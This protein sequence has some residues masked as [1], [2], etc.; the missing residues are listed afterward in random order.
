MTLATTENAAQPVTLPQLS[1][2]YGEPT[3]TA[4]LRVQPE[5]FMVH[6][7]LSFTPTGAGEHMLL[8]VE[9][10]GQNTQY[11]AKLLAEL[12]GCKAR[13]VSYAG[14]K[15]RHAITR[16]WFCVPVPIKQQL[17]WQQWQ[18]EGVKIL[19]SIRH[20]RRLKL[21]AI[22]YNQFSLML[23]EV[24]DIPALLARLELVKQGVPNYYGEQRFGIQG[25]NLALAEQLFSGAGIADR[26]IR[27]LALSASRSFLF[28][29]QL[30]ERIKAGFFNQILSGEVVQLDGS[31]SIF[32]VPEVDDSLKQRLQQADIHPTAGLPGSGEPLLSAEALHFE[33]K[34]LAPWQHWVD[35]LAD[36][37]V[38]A[39]RRAIR[40]VPADV[41][42][43]VQGQNVQ[44]SFKLYSGC[45]ATSVLRE[46]VKYRDVQ[47][48]Y[49]TLD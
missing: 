29:L 4:L 14:L 15:D 34:T 20:Q 13:Q 38:R 11:V 8:L 17:H 10:V 35:K 21:G 42:V 3:A 45:F 30:D 27:G 16:Q 26:K 23:R 12:V 36:L 2:L 25:G 33:Q 47:R 1:Y 37:N 32:K 31:G 18:I 46:L 48:K 19:D 40:V 28:N 7:Q 24:S 44:I 6:E 43:K 22:K 49:A 5:D 41:Q 39:E 9:K